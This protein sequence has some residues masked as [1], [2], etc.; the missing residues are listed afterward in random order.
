MNNLYNR[1]RLP[2]LCITMAAY[3]YDTFVLGLKTW[4]VHLI[5]VVHKSGPHNTNHHY[6]H[7]AAPLW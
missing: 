1:N 6:Q 5:Y 7:K 2:G 4:T 3:M